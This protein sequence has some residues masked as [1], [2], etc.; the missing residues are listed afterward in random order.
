M[1]NQKNKESYMIR[2]SQQLI[3]WDRVT[4]KL[5]LRV[6]DARDKSKTDLRHHLLKIQVVK[7]RTEAIL[8][9]LQIAENGNW[10]HIKS[11]LEK[12]WRLLRQRFSKASARP[13]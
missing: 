2:K 11:E 3:Q 1:E 12:S 13:K 10:Y 5:K 6:A 9:R 8:R 4:D 7:A